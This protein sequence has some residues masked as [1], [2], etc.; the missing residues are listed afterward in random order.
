MLIQALKRRRYEMLVKFRILKGET[1]RSKGR[2]STGAEKSH[3]QVENGMLQILFSAEWT[4]V[5]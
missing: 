4:G 5:V 1:S 3:K 2:Q